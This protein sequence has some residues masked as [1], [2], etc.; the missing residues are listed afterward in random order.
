[1]N[2][3]QSK[4]RMPPVRREHIPRPRLRALL[5]P[6]LEGRLILLSAPAGFGKTSLLSEWVQSL[7]LPVAWLS[8]DEQDNA[9]P[10]FLAYLL[11][12]VQAV[13]ASVGTGLLGTLETPQLPTFESA[14][15]ALPTEL[16]AV[17]KPFA[18][19]LDDFHAILDPQVHDLLTCL[20]DS[21]PADMRLVISGRS[22]PP[23][24]VGRLRAAGA[25]TE[26]RAADLRFTLDEAS[27]LLNDTLALHLSQQD[28]STVEERTEG[29]IAGLHLAALSLRNQADRPGFLQA[30]AGSD[31]FVLD[32]L[33]E[34]VLSQQPPEVCTFLLETSLLDR[35]SAPLC[36]AVTGRADSQAMLRRLEAD[37]LFVEP[38]DSERSWYAY[39][40]LMRSFLVSVQ[41]QRDPRGAAA[42][43]LRASHWYEAN[44]DILDA[45]QHGLAAE[46]YQRIGHL[47]RASGL[48]LVFQ[49]ELS[50][51]LTWLHSYSETWLRTGP[52]L[53][54]A[55]LWAHSF[56][57]D[58]PAIA[59]ELRETKELVQEGL[60]ALEDRPDSPKILELRHAL[61][62]L[63]AIE[64]NVAVM[65]GRHAEAAQLARQAL[66][67]LPTSDSTTRRYAFV[68]LGMA[69]RHQGELR[70]AMDA[71]AAADP[72][73]AG[74]DQTAA[75]ARGLATLA[76]VQIWMGRLQ[77]AEA[78]CRR[79]L[80]LHDEHLSRCGRRLPIAAFGYARLSEILLQ[81]NEL[82]EALRLAQESH[83][84]AV[85]WQ[86]TDAL[87]ESHTQ[88][89]RARLARGDAP[90]AFALLHALETQMRV[91]SPWLHDMTCV[92]EARLCL[93][94]A[95]DPACLDRARAWAREHPLP[96]DGKLVFRDHTLYLTHAQLML[97]EAREDRSRARAAAELTRKVM[98]LLEPTDA[99]GLLLQA[100]LLCALSESALGQSGE[101]LSHLL[102]CLH[103][104]EP[105]GYV[106]LFAD[107]GPAVG[108][109]L[110]RVP[111]TDP[112]HVYA[113]RLAQVM[114]DDRSSAKARQGTPQL[115]ARVAMQE[116]LSERELDVLRLLATTLSS[117]EIADELGVAT[118]TVR[119]H[120]KAIYSKLEVHNR[121]E[122]V[123]QARSLG[124][125]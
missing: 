20:V 3:L 52:W 19:I 15:A 89:A 48:A 79:L 49:G 28:L 104:A 11:T 90:G 1:M 6:G 46:D 76:G 10:R 84:L 71:L 92:E 30:F 74:V 101:A 119:S 14:R 108:A 72:P 32:Y 2:L 24:P 35:F 41:K 102:E 106:R 18:L 61:A 100:C 78:T 4:L 21:G 26:V 116:P 16:A 65:S 67:G 50:T 118:S 36:D 27:Q 59:D 91:S 13:D 45:I 115:P 37:N 54:I 62:H 114:A 99:L 124:L 103:R 122:A 107:H 75:P 55:Q 80:S 85:Q 66:A 88:L 34:E 40:S 83:L 68:C 111:A 17:R 98:R 33:M 7:D 57:T 51:V 87:F 82:D 81:R 93:M 97:W 73:E 86:Q 105:R 77:E 113:Q 95:R 96:A 64:A 117:S 25:L 70:E 109:M 125:L 9:W 29:W 110:A 44:G 69:L 58:A 60:H 22:D 112:S 5:R 63:T 120:T 31:R 94:C 8:L 53:R 47:I 12:A 43:H 23:W 123:D 42:I 39:H 121:L 38:L 56:S